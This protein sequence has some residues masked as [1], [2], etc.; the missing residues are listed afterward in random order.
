M[1]DSFV[2]MPVT[3]LRQKCTLLIQNIEMKRRMMTT[4]RKE[5]ILKRCI[6]E[7]DAMWFQFFRDRYQIPDDAE[8]EKRVKESYFPPSRKWKANHEAAT[9]LLKACEHSHD[10][11]VFVSTSQLTLITSTIL[12]I[13]NSDDHGYW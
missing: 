13:R 6:A 11:L 8:L 10:G 12:Y 4:H 7:R 3:T 2:K 9:A 5:D 1:E